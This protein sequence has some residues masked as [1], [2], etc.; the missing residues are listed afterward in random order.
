L[1]GRPGRLPNVEPIDL[2]TLTA[3]GR[4]PPLSILDVLG[5]SESQD[6]RMVAEG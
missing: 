5:S 6:E 2:E 1:L 3:A 4:L